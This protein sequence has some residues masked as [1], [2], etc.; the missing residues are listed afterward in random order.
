VF[1][2]FPLLALLGPTWMTGT[3]VLQGSSAGADLMRGNAPR[4]C[5]VL[6]RKSGATN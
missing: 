2:P 3:A 4:Q 5:P 1:I 6:R